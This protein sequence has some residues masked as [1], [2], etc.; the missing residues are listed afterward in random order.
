MFQTLRMFLNGGY[1]YTL[2]VVPRPWGQRGALELWKGAALLLTTRPWWRALGQLTL[3]ALTLGGRCLSR[4]PALYLPGI[5]MR[6]PRNQST[7]RDPESWRRLGAGIW[8]RPSYPPLTSKPPFR[9]LLSSLPHC[10][11][12]HLSRHLVDEAVEFIHHSIYPWIFVA[13]I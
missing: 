7:W 9:P 10:S 6:K 1:S 5:E 3:W 8:K 2:L 12:Y 13:N 4:V 11:P